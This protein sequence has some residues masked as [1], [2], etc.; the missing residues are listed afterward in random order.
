MK[1]LLLILAG[2]LIYAGWVWAWTG[3]DQCAW[4]SRLGTGTTSYTL[5]GETVT[6]PFTVFGRSRNVTQG[7][8]Y[9]EL[10][11]VEDTD[12]D[13]IFDQSELDNKQ[14]LIKRE[15]LNIDIDNI[16]LTPR[17]FV[18]S[19]WV[20]E[21]SRYFIVSNQKDLNGDEMMDFSTMAGLGED[22]DAT[23]PD[24]AIRYFYTGAKT[25]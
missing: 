2:I 6:T 21:G 4:I 24:S 13:T 14:L 1:K 9:T 18:D 11:L 10:Y 19:S 22:G 23:H 7:V 8:D 12:T 17:Y 20:T 16:Q 15:D 5:D 3:S 25:P